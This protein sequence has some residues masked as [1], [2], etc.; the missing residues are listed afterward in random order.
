MVCCILVFKFSSVLK[1]DRQ[2]LSNIY[3]YATVLAIM[4]TM[5]LV[6]LEN[7][8][9]LEISLGSGSNS[10]L[11]HFLFSFG[12]SWYVLSFS[13]TRQ[14]DSKRYLL[15]S[16]V[17]S[18]CVL[19]SNYI[20]FY[21]VLNEYV[22]AKPIFILMAVPLT[23]STSFSLTRFLIQIVNEESNKMTYRWA[24]WGSIMGGISLGSIPFVVLASFIDFERMY[25]NPTEP[26][27]ILI[28]FAF[29]ILANLGL[30][31]FPDF[32]GER[33]MQ[34]NSE[35]YKSLFKYNP[36]SVFWVEYISLPFSIS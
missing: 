3:K 19:G 34:K 11:I 22:A 17:L 12:A 9:Q 28:P 29:T 26:Y 32:F 20:G 30:M 4:F 33:L 8:F 23:I 7:S 31:L 13:Q 10:I 15:A 36:N 16:V 18:L 21:I 1:K 14:H 6:Y 5:S 2:R 24:F 25:S 35:S 27:A